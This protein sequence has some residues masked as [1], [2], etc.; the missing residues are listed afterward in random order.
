M[1]KKKEVRYMFRGLDALWHNNRKIEATDLY[2]MWNQY[3]TYPDDIEID[4]VENINNHYNFTRVGSN[5]TT[6]YSLAAE[7]ESLNKQRK[8]R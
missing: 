4:I 1:I 7:L 5:V 8:G 6:L 3:R 2:V